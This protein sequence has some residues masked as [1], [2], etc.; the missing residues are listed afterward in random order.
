MPSMKHLLVALLAA[1]TSVNASP[2]G[3]TDP[4]T[5][6]AHH[7]GM[8]K[9]RADKP[10]YI[11]KMPERCLGTSFINDDDRKKAWDESKA[12]LLADSFIRNNDMKLE[13]WV[14]NLFKLIFPEKDPGMY[15]CGEATTDCGPLPECHEFE[16]AGYV[17]GYYLFKS[18]SASHSFFREFKNQVLSNAVKNLLAVDKVIADFHYKPPAQN[19]ALNPF[20]IM[21]AAFG[22]LSGL[23]FPS[24]PL[25]G[26]LAAISGVSAL[27]ADTQQESVQQTIDAADVR[28][29]LS[30]MVDKAFDA[31]N[32]GVDNIIK[33]MYNGGP[34]EPLTFIENI[35]KAMQKEFWSTEALR[36]LG[37]GQWLNDNPTSGLQDLGNHMAHQMKQALAW[38]MLRI[39]REGF[40]VL[41]DNVNQGQCNAAPNAVWSDKR[42]SCFDLFHMNPPVK[43]MGQGID[44]FGDETKGLWS[45][46][47]MDKLATYENAAECWES[48]GGNMGEAGYFE[49]LTNLGLTKCTFG[50]PVRK[51]QVEVLSKAIGKDMVLDM[52]WPGQDKSKM[53]CIFPCQGCEAGFACPKINA[54]SQT[55]TTRDSY[56][57]GLQ[58]NCEQPAL[59]RMT[60]SAQRTDLW[61][62][63]NPDVATDELP[64]LK[65]PVVEPELANY[66]ES[67]ESLGSINAADR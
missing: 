20:A 52:S 31:G 67:A 32:D 13:N 58:L 55:S 2:L 3:P 53:A 49:D 16:E 5:T 15:S 40:V 64:E 51:G 23:S 6:P 11:P 33:A 4:N 1:S 62:Y 65:K 8:I 60:D 28:G 54:V 18:I 36:A 37:D 22:S 42:N 50:M 47:G 48:N 21:A 19:P 17:G 66:K 35:P 10:S 14:Q 61:Q 56:E 41:N 34:Q 63:V 27:I 57:P 26:G 30:A 12:G 29:S 24:G 44:D 46:Y 39:G 45:D 25:S 59:R 38:Q 43:N 9:A 7:G